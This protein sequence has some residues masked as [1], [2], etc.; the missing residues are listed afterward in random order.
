[1][2][3]I[4]SA[5]NDALQQRLTV[6]HTLRA[7]GMSNADL[8]HRL[9]EV[10][11]KA[12]CLGNVSAKPLCQGYVPPH[13]HSLSNSAGAHA[14]TAQNPGQERLWAAVWAR[15]KSTAAYSIRHQSNE[16]L[17]Q[18][19]KARAKVRQQMVSKRN[20]DSKRVAA[21]DLQEHVC[22][23]GTEFN[24]G[25][26]T[27]GRLSLLSNKSDHSGHLN[28]QDENEAV[29][30]YMTCSGAKVVQTSADAGEEAMLQALLAPT[31]PIEDF[32]GH[33]ADEDTMKLLPED[34]FQRPKQEV[35]V[36]I[37]ATTGLGLDA[38][39]KAISQRLRCTE[40]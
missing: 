37:S 14:S 36:V 12:D 32:P 29:H 34:T 26:V 20:K 19:T 17:L 33:E 7:L 11:N 31:G 9:L 30:P 3:V 6:L 4:D 38:L 13:R 23:G 8:R 21:L 40:I 22:H 1:M 24:M 2:H 28:R 16:R 5:S 35:P 25:H 27:D 39:K 18:L 10:W 15:L